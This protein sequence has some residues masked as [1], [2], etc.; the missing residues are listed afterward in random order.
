MKSIQT[1][2]KLILAPV[3]PRT[4]FWDKIRARCANGV[5]ELFPGGVEACVFQA[6]SQLS[7]LGCKGADDTPGVGF[8]N[9]VRY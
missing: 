3:P 6:Y 9:V 4:N 8:G 7:A 2:K 5:F 1:K